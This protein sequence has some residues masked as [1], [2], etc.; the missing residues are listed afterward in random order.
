[1]N[2]I[3]EI[4]QSILDQSAYIHIKGIQPGAGTYLIAHKIAEHIQAN[5]ELKP[6]K[7]WYGEDLDKTIK[8]LRQQLAIAYTYKKNI[9]RR[10]QCT[11]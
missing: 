2:K 5:Y 1:M 4:A 7:V 10:K 6:K 9:I 8:D 11:I 3:T